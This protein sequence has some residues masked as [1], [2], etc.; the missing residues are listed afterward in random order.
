[1]AITE[2]QLRVWAER[3]TAER[4]KTVITVAEAQILSPRAPKLLQRCDLFLQGSYAQKT[5]IGSSS[6]VDLLLISKRFTTRDGAALKDIRSW[7]REH[8][9]LKNTAYSWLKVCYGNKVF[10][11]RK[12]VHVQRGDGHNAMDILPCFQH[13]KNTEVNQM[14]RTHRGVSF[15]LNDGTMITN[16]PFALASQGEIKHQATNCYFKP[17]VRILKSMR[18]IAKDLDLPD[19]FFYAA[20]SYY[21]EGLLYNAPNSL[22]GGSYTE[23][24]LKTVA[25]LLKGDKGSYFCVNSLQRLCNDAE[26]GG[27]STKDCENFL[28]AM[29]HLWDNWN[30]LDG[31]I[32]E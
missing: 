5:N 18:D 8:A 24:F 21:I 31:P 6:D 13:V 17:M 12:V 32:A 19:K 9:L 15:F 22:F 30:R 3:G 26:M 25:W 2:G 11:N 29:M 27:W 1:M 23:T 10:L 4:L 16:F 20:P 14:P 28:I 7:Q